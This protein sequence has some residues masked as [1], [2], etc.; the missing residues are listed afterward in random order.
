[1]MSGNK[2]K[3]GHRRSVKDRGYGQFGKCCRYP[4]RSLLL[5]TFI[6]DAIEIEI[7]MKMKNRRLYNNPTKYL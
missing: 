7:E 2:K 3:N 4:A 6:Q 5:T 1:M